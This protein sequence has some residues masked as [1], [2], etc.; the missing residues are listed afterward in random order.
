MDSVTFSQLRR[1]ARIAAGVIVLSAA[2]I[3]AGGCGAM[4]DIS[5]S[6]SSL[7]GGELGGS[8]N[9]GGHP[10][11]GH[12]GK[13]GSGGAVTSA[14]FCGNGKIET[15]E[16]CDGKSFGSATCANQ[17]MGSRPY[18]TL[19]CIKCSIDTSGCTTTYPGTGGYPGYGGYYGYGGV[20]GTSGYYGAGGSSGGYGG[21]A[22]GTGWQP[23]YCYQ[24][25]GVLDTS[26]SCNFG[27]AAT[28]ACF[29]SSFSRS[30]VDPCS[31]KCGCS[32][33]AADYAECLSTPYCISFLSCAGQNCKTVDDCYRLGCSGIIDA[34]G[35]L[36]STAVRT[37]MNNTL[38]CL[39]N[40]SWCGCAPPPVPLPIK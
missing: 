23:D 27:S 17:T 4:T 22:G 10:T 6:D 32:F 12:S 20:A 40:N 33:C 9:G 26:G 5:P 31:A 14:P 35:G 3:Q 38:S 16:A 25:G 19:Q 1:H 18:G 24:Q 39:A 36:S 7:D 28:N 13:A 34:A 15:Y 30:S 8:E 11:G 37:V 21:T 2:G 29:N